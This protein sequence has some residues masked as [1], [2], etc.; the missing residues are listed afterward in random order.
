MKEVEEQLSAKLDS[1]V[2]EVGRAVMGTDLTQL[3]ELLQKAMKQYGA[4]H[5][6]QLDTQLKAL[7]EAAEED[8]LKVLLQ[9]QQRLARLEEAGAADPEFLPKLQA[10]ISTV[11]STVASLS[12]REDD[13]DSSI[14]A[15]Q[16]Q[17]A[18]LEKQHTALDDKTDACDETDACNRSTHAQ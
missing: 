2:E 5:R 11:E 8:L 12:D 4:Q 6:W 17:I 7:G 9:Q 18:A 16:E 1:A 10:H 14:T 15:L 13:T 3:A